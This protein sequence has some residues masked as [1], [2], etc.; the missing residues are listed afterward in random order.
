MYICTYMYIKAY[1]VGESMYMCTC[2]YMRIQLGRDT[3]RSHL[4]NWHAAL[5][6]LALSI[7]LYL[8]LLDDPHLLLRIFGEGAGGVT[9]TWEG[10]GKVE[11]GEREWGGAGAGARST[12]R[13]S[14]V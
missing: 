6:L 13:K 9:R 8:L 2:I 5:T 10:E 7:I 11:G 4:T 12:D 3:P 1:P 14:V